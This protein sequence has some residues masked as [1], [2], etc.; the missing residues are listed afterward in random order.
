[1][2]P[3]T[4]ENEKPCWVYLCRHREFKE[5]VD[6]ALDRKCS[7][8]SFVEEDYYSTRSGNG[9]NGASRNEDG[10]GISGLAGLHSVNVQRHFEQFDVLGSRAEAAMM[11]DLW[12]GKGEREIV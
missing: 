10:G 2:A 5:I 4:E 7:G 1:M 9:I 11:L 6:R 3:L 8:E 12:E